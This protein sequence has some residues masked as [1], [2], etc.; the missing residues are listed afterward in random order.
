[1]LDGCLQA[2]SDVPKD[3]SMK[4]VL[5]YATVVLMTLSYV[6]AQADHL[7]IV[8][9]GDIMMGSTYPEDTLPP[10]DGEGVFQN[11]KP[12][13]Q[14][15]DVVFGNLEGPLLDQGETTKCKDETLSCYAFRTPTRYARHLKEAGFN[16]L[17]I[18]NNHALD[19][20]IDGIENTIGAVTTVGVKPSGG[21]AVATLDVGRRRVAVVGFSFL[22]SRY[23]ASIHD[24]TK[25]KEIVRKAKETHDIVIVSFHGGAEGKNALHVADSKE[26]F[27]NENRGN[28]VEFSKAVIDAG[29]DMVVGHG[30]HVLRALELYRGKLISYSLGNFVTYGRFNIQGP[31]GVSVILKAV[32]DAETGNL[33]TGDVQPV[34][35][36]NRGIP[37]L[38]EDRQ[39]IQ[40]LQK[41]IRE[42]IPSPGVLVADDGTLNIDGQSKPGP[43]T[44]EIQQEESPTSGGN[45][46]CT[47]D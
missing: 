17:S 18:A 15:W 39:A 40:L 22:P 28:V 16:T 24:I 33:L 19:F 14:G 27:L 4:S 3:A 6:P 30:P 29:A 1:M 7:T 11:V 12:A 47:K 31:S 5:L 44:V 32:L 42:D 43:L 23:S 36:R 46:S 21:N 45:A 10:N 2:L 38:D 20:G 37:E 9:V 41:L 13:L 34:R 35:L 8:A 25:A 26:F